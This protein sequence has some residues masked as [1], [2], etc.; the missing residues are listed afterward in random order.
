MVI[1]LIDGHRMS[2]ESFIQAC[3]DYRELR[4]DFIA[5]DS[6]FVTALIQL[7]G[8]LNGMLENPWGSNWEKLLNGL[9]WYARKIAEGA[10]AVCTSDEL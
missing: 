9:A 1:N 6:N 10:D 5:G 4:N 2:I 8:V 7:Q 3:V